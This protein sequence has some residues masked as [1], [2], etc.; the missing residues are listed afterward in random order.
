MNIASQSRF[1]LAKNLAPIYA[2][3]PR[4]AAVLVG[5][6]T[7][8]GHADRFSDIELGVFWHHPPTDA[9]REIAARQI[10]ADFVRLH[11]YDPTEEVWCD[12]YLLGRHAD[13]PKTGLLVEVV[14]YTTDFLSRTFHDVLELH[15]PDLAKQNLI[16]GV[17][18]SIPLYQIETVEEWKSRAS[19]YPDPLAVAMIKRHAQIDHFWR[20]QMWIERSNNLMQLYQSYTQVQQQLLHV[21]LGVNRVYY[22]GFKWLDVVVKQLEH[23]PDDLLRRLRQVYEVAPAEGAQELSA[24]VE[25]TYIIIAQQFPQVDVKW[26]RNVFYHQRSLWNEAPTWFKESML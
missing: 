25:E 1:A 8:R 20:W 4:V 24:L 23:R 18:S 16:A 15:N 11:P 10:Q 5:G 21:L 13:Q 26:L 14:H 2:S 22:F 19:P 12:N 17:L 7:A 3:N 6:S 9:D